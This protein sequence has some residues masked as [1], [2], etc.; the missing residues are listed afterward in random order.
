MPVLPF[1]S[2]RRSAN[3]RNH[4]KVAVFD[5]HTAIVGGHNLAREYMGPQPYRK[6][7]RDFGAVLTGPAAA[8][9][10]EIFLADWAF[11]SGK[12]RKPWVRKLPRTRSAAAGKANC[13]SS[14]A[15]PTLPAIR[16]TRAL[17]P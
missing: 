7:F 16:S 11:A 2:F 9:V 4:R 15:G 10:N 3:L 12:P 8:M 14:R 5:G 6:R 1:T 17:C 13:R